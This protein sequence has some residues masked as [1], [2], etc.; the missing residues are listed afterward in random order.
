MAYLRRLIIII[1]IICETSRKVL[2]IFIMI[3]SEHTQ[4]FFMSPKDQAQLINVDFTIAI[5]ADFLLLVVFD[6]FEPSGI[7]MTGTTL[8]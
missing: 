3:P 8:D 5:F 6:C 4:T 7:S 2:E 1:I